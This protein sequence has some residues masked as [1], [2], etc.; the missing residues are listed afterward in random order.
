MSATE[1]VQTAPVV[2]TVLT[3]AEKTH[4]PTM[5]I[6]VAAAASEYPALLA[7]G[8]Q[9]AVLLGVFR[10]V[11][12]AMFDAAGQQRT[13]FGV[14]AVQIIADRQLPGA[15]RINAVQL[16]EVRVGD[17]AIFTDVP[18]PGAD[19]IGGG[20]RQLQ[21]LFGVALNPEAFVRTLL[22][23]QSDAPPFV[24]FNRGNE[25]PGYLCVFITDRAIREIKPELRILAITLQGEALFTVG[26]YLTL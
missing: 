5:V 7:A 25:D 16:G 15:G 6:L 26:A 17:K 11:G 24:G 12:D 9:Q 8:Q 23:L 1:S 2:P 19:R 20:E 14:N 22:Q 18:V 3:L 21:S 13:V 10:A 4:R